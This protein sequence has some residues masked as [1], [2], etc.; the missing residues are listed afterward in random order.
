MI[1]NLFLSPL[2]TAE[3]NQMVLSQLDLNIQ[4]KFFV[5]MYRLLARGNIYYQNYLK[6]NKIFVHTLNIRKNNKLIIQHISNNLHIFNINQ[7]QD[8]LKIVQHMNSWDAQ[9]ESL[10]IKFNPTTNDVFVFDSQ[11]KFPKNSLLNLNTY[12]STHLKKIF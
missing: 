4:E 1:L 2:R 7:R 9:W 11:I 6:Y 12:Y 8:L 10:R 5:S 3:N